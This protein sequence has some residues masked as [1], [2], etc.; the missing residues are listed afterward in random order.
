MTSSQPDIQTYLRVLARR[1]LT[2]LLTTLAVPAIALAYSFVKQPV[3][4]ASA[5]VLVPT[6]AATT[7]LAPAANQSQLPAATSLQRTLADEQRFAQGD[8]TRKA[9][10]ATLHYVPSISISVSTT[11]DVLTFTANTSNKAAAAAAA[12]AY[13]DGYIKANRT[14]QL[15]QFTQQLQA[16]QGSIDQAQR[17]ASSLPAKSQQQIAAEASISTL[18]QALQNLQAASQLTTQ[19]GPSVVAAATVPNSP[20]SPNP[21]RNGLLGL[22]LG[23][24][25]GVLLAFL[26][27]RL[28]DKIRSLSDV[29]ANS[30]GRPM[31]GTVPVVEAWRKVSETHLALVEDSTSTASEAYRT[32]RTA[33]Q[34]LGIDANQR[35]I[36][37]TSSVAGEGK[38]TTVANLAVS[39][40]RAGQRVIVVSCDFRRPRLHLFFGVENHLGVTSV[41]LGEASSMDSLFRVEGEPNLWVLPSGPIPPNPAEILSLDRI[42][43]LIEGLAKRADVVLVDCPPVLPVSDTLLVSRLCDTLLVVT[44]ALTTK[45]SA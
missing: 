22:L 20:S 15:D 34:F 26:R 5:Q 4:A 17:K 14:N 39:F 1:K 8:A 37:V 13:A 29:D 31:I 6:Q 7:V 16:L 28:D 9:V 3:Y 21:I 35:V 33:I 11:A 10:A 19:S 44:A 36:G 30:G 32:L 43:T 38:T 2:I 12:N 18:T 25:L 23:I 45:K 41:L 27:D 24:V 42:R 40:A